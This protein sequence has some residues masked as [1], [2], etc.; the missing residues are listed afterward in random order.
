MK[1][2]KTYKVTNIEDLFGKDLIKKMLDEKAVVRTAIETNQTQ[3]QKS[4]GH[5]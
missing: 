2:K 1:N 4:N 5:F 3:T